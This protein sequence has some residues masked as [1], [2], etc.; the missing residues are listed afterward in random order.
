MNPLPKLTYTQLHQF[1][2]DACE[3]DDVRPKLDAWAAQFSETCPH[4]DEPTSRHVRSRHDPLRSDPFPQ[5]Q[6]VEFICHYEPCPVCRLDRAGVALKF[7]RFSFETFDAATD[8][9][10]AN[11]A[12]VQ[13]FAAAPAGFL[14]LL[15]RNGTGKTHLAVAALRAFGRGRFFSHADLVNRLRASYGPSGRESDP[16][17][18]PEDIAEICRRTPLLVIAELGLATGGNDAEVLLHTILDDRV[19][20]YRPTVLSANIPAGDMESTFGSRLAD[21]FREAVFAVLNF[22][23]PSRRAAG[24][25][26]YLEAARRHRG[27][28]R[29]D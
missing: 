18:E 12:K 28:S 23:G 15:G 17:N 25:A 4:H 7:Q 22:T 14:F 29:R 11:L 6:A 3:E 8:E 10:R 26:A 13:E 21:R 16:E 9:L 24:N 27:E 20:N 2:R 5:C 1:P 19:S